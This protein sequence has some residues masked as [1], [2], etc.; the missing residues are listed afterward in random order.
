MKIML[1]ASVRNDRFKT[2]Q[3]YEPSSLFHSFSSLLLV[4]SA[5]TQQLQPENSDKNAKEEPKP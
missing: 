4:E 1:T 5:V 2:R 3:N